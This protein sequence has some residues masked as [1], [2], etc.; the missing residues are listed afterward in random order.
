MLRKRI[1]PV[2]LLRN[3]SLVKT[4]KFRKFEYVGNPLNTV[5][6]FNELEV[7]ELII[8]DILTSKLHI[9]P[10]WDLLKDLAS[11]CFMPLA[12]GGGVNSLDRA[13]KIF[14]L[15]FEKIIINSGLQNNFKL[16]EEISNYF[17]TQALIVSIDIKY[18]IFNNPYVSF[19]CGTKGTSINPISWAKKCQEVGA[20]E[21]FITSIKKEGM[22]NGYDVSI[23]KAITDAVEIPI[24]AN[25]GAG[26]LKDIRNL[27]ASTN[28][29]AAAASSIFLFQKK[30][31]GVLI[32][33]PEPKTIDSIIRK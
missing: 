25:G 6:I 12:Y 5:A 9:E 31:M 14:D 24:I 19:I 18:S 13:K 28:I 20:G 11:E 10:N 26:S 7:D 17:G 23:I 8:N 3:T 32:N 2:L 33:Y 16:I 1:I 29:N 4:K 27:F 30:D 15:G 22:W 21:L